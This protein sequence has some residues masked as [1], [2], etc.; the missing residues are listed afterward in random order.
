MSMTGNGTEDGKSGPWYQVPVWDGSPLTWREFQRSMKWW[1]ASL[2]L[3]STARYNLAARWLLRQTG[4]VR[5]RGE[6]FDPKDLEFKPA[7]EAEDP[8]TG[9][10]IEIEKPDYLHGLNK[11]L[12]ALEDING[13]TVLDS[14]VSCVSSSM[15]N[16][17]GALASEF[18]SLPHVFVWPWQ[19][20]KQKEL[21][22]Q[23][24]S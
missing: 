16:C 24:L 1:L 20:F 7:V 2:D 11:L 15:S 19:I 6:E 13:M 22:C 18:L 14:E 12:R 3:P 9:E 4:I 8:T 21:C 17:K 5:Q 23:L 10:V